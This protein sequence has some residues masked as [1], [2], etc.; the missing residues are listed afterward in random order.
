MEAGGLAVP[1]LRSLLLFTTSP[2]R[3]FRRLISGELHE[4]GGLELCGSVLLLRILFICASSFS[5]DVSLG[6]LSGGAGLFANDRHVP[7]ATLADMFEVSHAQASAAQRLAAGVQKVRPRKY[8]AT[9]IGWV[10]VSGR[11]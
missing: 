11:A 2:A 10:G 7:G 8:G 1:S 3:E 9:W 6:L 4:E 5:G